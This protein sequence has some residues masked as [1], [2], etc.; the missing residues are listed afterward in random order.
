MAVLDV[1]QLDEV[2]LRMLLD[3]AIVD[4]L[5][6]AD[7]LASVVSRGGGRD[8]ESARLAASYLQARDRARRLRR[9]VAARVAG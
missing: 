9:A 3:D 7:G 4:A 6:L 8:A 1:E 5:E 2:D